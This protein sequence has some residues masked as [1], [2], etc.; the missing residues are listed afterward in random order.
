MVAQTQELQFTY[1][2]GGA[3]IISIH[4][5]NRSIELN[6]FVIGVTIIKSSEGGTS[7]QYI[8]IYSE[9]EP[10][11]ELKLDTDRSVFS[12]LHSATK[13]RIENSV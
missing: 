4:A 6:D 3:E 7:G 2:P 13:Q 5:F 12:S 9:W 8:N 1:L 11:T 10:G